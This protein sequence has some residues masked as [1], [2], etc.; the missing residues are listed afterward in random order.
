MF[1]NT[2]YVVRSFARRSEARN[3]KMDTQRNSVRNMCHQTKKTNLKI[4]RKQY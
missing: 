4:K 2:N 3:L 1:E